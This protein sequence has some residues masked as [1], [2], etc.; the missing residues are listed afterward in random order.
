MQPKMIRIDQ[1]LHG[2]SRG[3]KE[4]ASSAELDER[5]RTTM[6]MMSDLLAVIDLPPDESYLTIYPLKSASRHVVARTW[7]AGRNYRP[8]SVWTHSLIL[9]Y[10]ALTLI[11]DLVSLLSH[12]VEPAEGVS[13][14]YEK[15]LKV[16]ANQ[17]SSHD[18][19]SDERI[20][21]A[22]RQLY[23]PNPQ[24]QIV[25]P[26]VTAERDELLTLA[27]W[28]QMWPGMRR[29]F[30]ALT[31]LGDGSV[32]FESGCTLRFANQAAPNDDEFN[33][34]IEAGL[35]EL[36][37]DFS[38]P[39]PTPLRSFLGRYAIEAQDP[40]RLAAALAVSRVDN[41][42]P[43]D[44]QLK[45]LR[46]FNGGVVL[47][48]FDRDLLTQVFK[49]ID[50]ATRLISFV[51]STRN[52]EIDIDLTTLVDL[53]SVAD[54]DDLRDLIASTGPSAPGELGAKLHTSLLKRLPVDRLARVATED[55]RPRMAELRPEL[56]QV[57]YFWPDDDGARAALVK[58]LAPGAFD[59]S[60][61][62][63]VFGTSI[64]VQTLS[65]LMDGSVDLPPNTVVS[66]LKVDESAVREEMA[67]WAVSSPTLLRLIANKR[68]VLDQRA[69]EALAGAQISQRGPLSDMQSWSELIEAAIEAGS[70]RRA[71]ALNVIGYVCSLAGPANETLRIAKAVFDP[72][73]SALR[74]RTLSR[75]EDRYLSKNISTYS[76][77]WPLS[78]ALIQS[79]LLKWPVTP[80]Q[81]GA[82]SITQSESV[83]DEIIDEILDKNSKQGL[84]AL[85]QAPHLPERARA[86][87][88][89]RLMQ[90]KSKKSNNPWSWLFDD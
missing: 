10:Q 33:P 61:A 32:H 76:R 12:F 47:P 50:S 73:H 34:T 65:A 18:L 82:L 71:E 17:R 25:L 89:R 35:K 66:L 74:S 16:D 36:E 78:K 87:I 14:E 4:L 29:D 52:E 86:E 90:P 40:R 19:G 30:S 72:L 63:K 15:P 51:R 49:N 70:S 83:Q 41:A 3:H 54:I 39:G 24:Q 85:L 55:H 45:R 8:G 42:H 56:L 53:A 80:L 48:R 6:L 28:R 5:S 44:F 64:G 81:A 67:A 13:R 68:H 9:D 20:S 43:I 27:I 23:G 26:H 60:D 7:A 21:A 62:L 1:A 37:A 79:A 77:S 69:I 84:E 75:D 88:R 59:I 31:N 22:L 58:R 2:Y 11:P 57:P 46:G 38:E